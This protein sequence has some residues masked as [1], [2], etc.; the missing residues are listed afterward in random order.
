MVDT[1]HPYS[2]I[3]QHAR[4]RE[5]LKQQAVSIE[6]AEAVSAARKDPVGKLLPFS[7]DLLKSLG[8]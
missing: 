7:L 5:K 2:I 1:Y 3:A 4:M 8:E 6:R